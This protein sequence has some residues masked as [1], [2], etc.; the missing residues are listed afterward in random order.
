MRKIMVSE[1]KT[2]IIIDED[3]EKGTEAVKT[4]SIQAEDSVTALKKFRCTGCT[5]YSTPAALQIRS[6]GCSYFGRTDAQK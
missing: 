4:M 2:I 6:N 1:I 5:T 3:G